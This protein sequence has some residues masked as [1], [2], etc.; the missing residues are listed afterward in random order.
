[1]KKI[2]VLCFILMGIN[3]TV[4]ALDVE[5]GD[6]P[7]VCANMT[8]VISPSITGGSG[9]YTIL[10]KANGIP[11]PQ[12]N[13]QV[14]ISVVPSQSTLYEVEVRDQESNYACSDDIFI[15]IWEPETILYKGINN[16]ENLTETTELTSCRNYTFKISNENSGAVL[17]WH[18]YDIND[19]LGI[20]ST[21]LAGGQSDEFTYKFGTDLGYI[22]ICFWCDANGNSAFD[23][24]EKNTY[25]DVYL[26]DATDNNDAVFLENANASIWI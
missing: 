10:W 9:S 13:N 1:M 6:P 3:T 4:L 15:F 22:R 16:F 18:V 17:N 19:I 11:Q 20:Q 24:T 2:F 14:S 23:A 7:A 21:L 12:W 5:L 8:L 26:V 25:V